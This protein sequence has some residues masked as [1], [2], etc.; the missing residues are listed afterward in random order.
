MSGAVGADAAQSSTELCSLNLLLPLYLTPS[1]PAL[2]T[3]P[4]L[5]YT[6][7]VIMKLVQFDLQIFILSNLQYSDV[8]GGV[9]CTDWFKT[10]IREI[11]NEGE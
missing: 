7:F 4:N 11:K 10:S 3:P 2:Q 1:L 9:V 5:L 6:L 8:W